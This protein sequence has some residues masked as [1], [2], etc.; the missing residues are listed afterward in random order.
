MTS[1]SLLLW[2]V[3]GIALQLAIFLGI[4]FWRHWLNYHALRSR[5]AGLDLPVMQDISSGEEAA[6]VAAWPGCRTFRVDRR[7]V[8]DAAQSVCSFYLM[9]EDG[10]PLPPFKPGQFL[11]FRPDIPAAIRSELR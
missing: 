6:V 3:S 11:T 9:P 1:L 8:E 4:S 2:I 5:A 10:Q 7:V